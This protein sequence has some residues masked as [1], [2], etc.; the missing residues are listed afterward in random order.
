MSSRSRAHRPQ[1]DLNSILFFGCAFQLNL[2]YQSRHPSG[3]LVAHG[4]NPQD[5]ANSP[6]QLLGRYLSRRSEVREAN[7]LNIL[8][9]LPLFG[10]VAQNQ[11]TLPEIHPVSVAYGLLSGRK[12]K[13]RSPL[14]ERSDRLKCTQQ[15]LI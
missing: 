12:D 6:L 3:S 8:R 7:P 2:I 10:R 14:N 13:K 4:G 1:T 15:R 11:Q 5:R 9:A